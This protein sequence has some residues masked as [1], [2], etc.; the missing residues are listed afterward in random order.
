MLSIDNTYSIEEL[1]KF[2]ERTA[3]LLPGEP[4]EWVVELKID[5]VA[6][7]LIYEDGLLVAGRHP[8]QRPRGRRHHPQRPHDPRR[9]AAAARQQGC[10]RCWRSAA[11][12][13]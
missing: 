12:S 4:I 7:S 11:R 5:G 6:V 13:T 2:G 3:K 9:A 1:R 10:R 8:G